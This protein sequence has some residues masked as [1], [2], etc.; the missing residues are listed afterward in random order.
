MEIKIKYLPG[1]TKLKKISK[2]DWI[3]LYSYD[4]TFLKRRT[5]GKIS[6]GIAMELPEGYEAEVKPRSSTFKTWGI[7]QTNSVGAIDNSYCG[8]NDIWFMPYYATRDGF[9]NEGDKICQFRIRKKQP[10][11]ELIE[12]ECLGNKD[13]G[14]YGSTGR[15]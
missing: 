6:L 5:W 15:K 2:G 7:L 11:F 14:G 13:R 3:D 1:A 9:I 10:V 8:D 12:V 4:D